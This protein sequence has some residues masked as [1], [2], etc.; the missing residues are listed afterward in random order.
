[1]LTHYHDT[2][3]SICVLDANPSFCL[4]FCQEIVGWPTF[5]LRFAC[6]SAVHGCGALRAHRMTPGCQSHISIRKDA[7][8]AVTLVSNDV[9]GA[10]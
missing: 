7:S 5:F 10:T 9:G 4:R 3:I 2:S 8:Q 1:M 6:D